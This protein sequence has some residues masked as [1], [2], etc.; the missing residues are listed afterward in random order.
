MLIFKISK[1]ILRLFFALLILFFFIF[2]FWY[3]GLP[4]SLINKKIED[5]FH[6]KGIGIRLEGIRKGIFYSLS[7]G[8]LSLYRQKDSEGFKQP[9]M[10]L[11]DIETHL[12]LLS[13][14][15]L[16]PRLLIEA[17]IEDSS[18]KGEFL[19]LGRRLNLRFYNLRLDSLGFLTNTEIKG[20]GMSSGSISISLKDSKGE[21]RFQIS[22]AR[23]KDITGSRYIPLSL[24][25][26]IRGLIVIDSKI[27]V[28]K[29][30]SFNGKGIY[31][32]IENAPFRIQNSKIIF[33]GGSKIELM[34]DSD[35]E[36][37]NLVDIILFRYKKS[38]GYYIIP[39]SN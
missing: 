15:R 10:I 11:S 2:G 16:K 20:T 25:S 17:Y 5:S 38:P 21:L 9:V 26:T 22:E 1:I 13:V 3:I 24:F 4:E 14:L 12:D 27:I 36:I 35:F 19:L 6:N 18:I 32:R 29:S 23:L 31:G 28:I 37:P 7:I 34:V 39:L 8:R 33:S 30:L